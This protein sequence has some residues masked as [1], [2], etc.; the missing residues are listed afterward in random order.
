MHARSDGRTCMIEDDEPVVSLRLRLH[1]VTLL[2]ERVHA[3]A[4]AEAT[5]STRLI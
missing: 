3:C 5:S 2:G 1:Y 4:A